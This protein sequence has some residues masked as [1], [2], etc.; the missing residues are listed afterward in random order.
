VVE[1]CPGSQQVFREPVLNLAGMPS[2]CM[3][4]FYW[5]GCNSVRMIVQDDQMFYYKSIASF[6]TF[7]HVYFFESRFSLYY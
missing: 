5:V 4:C 7:Y 2:L 3:S 6:M 1:G